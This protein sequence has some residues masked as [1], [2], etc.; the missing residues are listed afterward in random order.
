MDTQMDD[1]IKIFHETNY[2]AWRTEMK[3]YLKAKGASV[4]KV[5]IG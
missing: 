4:W 5:V 3:G 1:E 2:S